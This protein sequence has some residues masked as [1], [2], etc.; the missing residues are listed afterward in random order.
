MGM[1][2]GMG[3]VV[4]IVVGIVIVGFEVEVAVVTDDFYV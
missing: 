2:M 1:G 4:G 3:I